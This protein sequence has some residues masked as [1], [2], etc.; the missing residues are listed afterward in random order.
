MKN[1]CYVFA[2]IVFP[3][4]C[5]AEDAKDAYEAR[6]VIYTGGE[7]KEEVFHYRLLKPAK[8]EEG[9]KYPVIFFLHGAGER[10]DDNAKQL[11]HFAGQMAEQ[12]WRT[13]LF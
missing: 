11:V 1:L 2:V 5:S 4:F 8:I 10:G 9:K 13:N 12:D 7:Y 3:I 6:S